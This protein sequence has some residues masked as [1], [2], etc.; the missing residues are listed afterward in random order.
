MIQ[1]PEEL[2][3]DLARRKAVLVLGAGISMNAKTKEGKSPKSWLQLLEEGAK[4]INPKPRKIVRR[5]LKERDFLTA[6]EIVKAE[7]GKENYETFLTEEFLDPKFKPALVHD[8]LFKLDSRIVVTPNIDKI[9]EAR[10]N[11]LGQASI[12]V[13][14]YYDD[15]VA[16]AIR[17]SNR[18]ILKVHGTIDTPAKMIFTRREY[19]AA[20]AQHAEFYAILD[21]LVITHT[22]VFIG[23]GVSDPD[24]R[25]VLENYAFRFRHARRHFITLPK[26]SMEL[27]EVRALED[28]MNLKVLPYTVRRNSHQE[29]VE[30]I[31][32]LQNLVDARRGTLAE[33]MDW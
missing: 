13:K 14:H 33:N 21:A 3:A 10:A 30:S 12:K 4:K 17:R 6:C 27:E 11:H 29:L 2:T 32:D 7:L 20:R 18:V 9:Y 28:S 5:L 26:D 31:E 23:C 16:D 1:W 19:A 15:D 25:L 8:F 24:I 22:F